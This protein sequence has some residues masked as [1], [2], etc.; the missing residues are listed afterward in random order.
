MLGRR[1]TLLATVLATVLLALPACGGDDTTDRIDHDRVVVAVGDDLAA[2][3][4]PDDELVEQFCDARSDWPE[5]RLT[6]DVAAFEVAH[7]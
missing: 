1:T 5:A 2:G 3:R 7:C 6:D 4:T